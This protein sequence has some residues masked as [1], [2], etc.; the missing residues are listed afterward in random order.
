MGETTA[1][2]TSTTTAGSRRTAVVLGI[3]GILLGWLLAAPM[4]AS[5]SGTGPTAM[6][7][8]PDGLVGAYDS[9]YGAVG[10]PIGL[11]PY[12]FWG[13]GAFLMYVAGLVVA[14]ALPAALSSRRSRVG[15][16]VLLGA[17]AV[18]LVGDLLGYWS[19]WGSTEMGTL[20]SI[21]FVALEMPAMLAMLVGCV[22][23]G[24]GFRAD[25][26]LPL[27]VPW[28]LVA[29]VVLVPAFNLLVIGYA[30]HGVLVPVLGV[31]TVTVAAARVPA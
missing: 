27:W 7:Y 14:S 16:R 17:F 29:V 28:L 13:K 20:T 22:V 8:V 12:Y 26:V 6:P 3:V 4:E 18:G 2:S 10:E 11:T 5:F 31:L 15:R 21:G 19:G 25:G 1:T 23:L 30:P 24:L 9:V